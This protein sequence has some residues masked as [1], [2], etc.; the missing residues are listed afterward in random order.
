MHRASG[1]RFNFVGKGF[2]STALFALLAACGD[3]GVD[4]DTAPVSTPTTEQSAE[5]S[6][7]PPPGTPVPDPAPEL[8]P[9]PQAEPW[10]HRLGG[11]QDD[12]GTG[13]AV[14]GTGH[15]S[16]A[17]VSTPRQDA[18]RKPV[19]GERLS[20]NLARYAPDGRTLWTRD[21]PRNRVEALRVVA[22]PE[23]ALFVTGNAFLYD[24]DFGLGAASKGFLVKFS[25]EGTALWQRRVG[26]KV[27]A[28]VAD[29]AGGVLVAGEDWT[30]GHAP[31][32]ARYDAEGNELWTR[33]LD[34]VDEGSEL[35]AVAL[36]PSGQVLLA[37]RLQGALTVD[38]QTFGAPGVQGLLL[39]SF[40][41]DGRLAWGTES[42]GVDGH[43]SSVRADAD[44]GAVLAGEFSGSFS[45]GGTPL[46]G[47]GAFVL[48]VGLGGAERW[49]RT[50]ACGASPS[51]PAVA[52]DG[53]GQVVALCGALLSTY[54]ADGT[55]RE[56]QPLTP[57]ECSGQTCQVTGTAL[58]VVPGKGLAL[59]GRQL[60][61]DAETG[62]QEA[63]VRLL[64][65]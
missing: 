12:V 46:S 33:R 42:R 26:Q 28:S 13:L 61:G 4:E 7:L 2:V 3:P 5:G 21:F 32:L 63:F 25:P 50:L 31:L 18:D 54:T 51:A 44:G 14:D 65:P 57:G 37:G 15:V 30:N 39:L 19:E 8:P 24:I 10:F 47:P 60:H 6:R 17:W 53:A 56:Q 36:G 52:R 48:A 59:T 41:Q 11:P 35:R 22:A 27:Y 45:W 58:D 49:A 9:E 55:Q 20:L 64:T 43:V 23:G 29:G 1:R 38:G 62:D 16:V 34:A 40:G